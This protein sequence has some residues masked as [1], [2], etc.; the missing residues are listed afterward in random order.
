M[1]DAR[2]V[3][4]KSGLGS[5]DLLAQRSGGV[6]APSFRA[7]RAAS[8]SPLSISAEARARIAANSGRSLLKLGKVGAEADEF[9]GG[10]GEAV[11][12]FGFRDLRLTEALEHFAQRR[13]GN[14]FGLGGLAAPIAQRKC[15]MSAATWTA[16]LGQLSYLATVWF[17]F[18]VF[19]H[20]SS[21]PSLSGSCSTYFARM[22]TGSSRR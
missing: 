11:G 8:N 4:E 1:V 13:L 20:A 19:F 17:A 14:A 15:P 9:V 2:L 18:S 3:G 12:D 6:A 10:F 21:S 16:S 22:G 5:A 7:A